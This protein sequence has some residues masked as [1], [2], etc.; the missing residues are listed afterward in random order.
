MMDFTRAESGAIRRAATTAKDPDQAAAELFAMLDQPDL[1]LVLVFVSPSYDLP[2][3][4]EALRRVFPDVPLAG[5]SSAGEITPEGY[6]SGGIS[7]LSLAGPDFAVACELIES[8]HDFNLQTGRD[9]VRRA[10]DR[11]ARARPQGR[12]DQIFA[13]ALIDG[14]SGAEE[15]V[16]S[17]L[18]GALDEIPLFGGSAGDDLRFQR[19]FVLHDGVFRDNCALMVLVSTTHPFR[20]FKTEH[21]EATD[22]KMVVTQADPVHRIVSEIDA[23]PAAVEYA[24]QVG[25]KGDALTPLIFANHPVVVRVGGANFVR[26]IQKVNDDGSL[27]FF[28]AIDE[29]IVLTVARGVDLA[30]NLR[31]QFDQLEAEIGRPALVIGFDCILRA[32]ELD[33]RN[34]RS[35]VGQMMAEHNVIGFST[36][37]EQFDAMHVNQT[38]T[39]V[40][41]GFGGIERN[42]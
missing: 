21:F 39:G 16:V 32:L 1:S 28:C 3:V 15:G 34:I 41:I 14:L 27:T 42:Q 35:E 10:L 20:V 4:A 26:S 6:V 19:T 8:L 36:Y 22:R 5:C 30:D 29:G 33:E 11:V 37:G 31:A 38:F 13:F 2:A 7:A 17:A 25:L 18:H 40:A 9:V 12:R 24:R 23:E